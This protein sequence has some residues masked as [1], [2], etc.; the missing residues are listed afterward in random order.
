MD[1]LAAYQPA[2]TSRQMEGMNV[3][4][5]EAAGAGKHFLC[6]PKAQTLQFRLS[7]SLMPPSDTN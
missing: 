6:L 4:E 2:S 3:D 1:I 7:C 5:E